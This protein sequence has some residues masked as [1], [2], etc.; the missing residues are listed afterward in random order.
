[1]RGVTAD[2]RRA[3]HLQAL[4]FLGLLADDVSLATI[5]YPSLSEVE[6]RALSQLA[7]WIEPTFPTDRRRSPIR[8]PTYL[9]DPTE[10]LHQTALLAPRTTPDVS[11]PASLDL[12]LGSVRKLLDRA[13]DE[14]ELG[15]V[16]NFAEFLARVTLVLTEQLESEKGANDWTPAASSFS[17]SL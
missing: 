15:A 5:H 11:E 4:T 9:S 7:E 14:R 2:E 13:A 17:V 6:E 1:M 10:L 8:R 16:R 12:L 3:D